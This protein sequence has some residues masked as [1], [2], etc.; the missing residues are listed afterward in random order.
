MAQRNFPPF[1][2][3]KAL[4]KFHAILATGVFIKVYYKILNYPS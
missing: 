3:V 4:Q 2:E 1:D